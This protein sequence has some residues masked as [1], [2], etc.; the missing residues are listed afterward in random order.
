LEGTV[1]RWLDRV[2]SGFDAVP[3]LGPRTV[4]LLGV[5]TFAMTL[6]LMGK[7]L[8]I[9]VALVIAGIVATVITTATGKLAGLITG[10]LALVIGFNIVGVKEIGKAWTFGIDAAVV[11]A[12]A[13]GVLAWWRRDAPRA[14]SPGGSPEPPSR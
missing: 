6:I 11:V 7:V 14:G 8:P 2:T 9:M 13:L 4:A 5:F 12:I 10:L 1:P 3:Q